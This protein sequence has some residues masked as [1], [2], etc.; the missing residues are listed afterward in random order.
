MSPT[1]TTPAMTQAGMI[2][3]TAAYM[4]PEQARGK[5]VDKRAD[6][7][8]FGVVLFEMLTG[9]RAFPG[10]D[11]TDTLAAVVQH[12]AG[13]GHAACRSAF[14]ALRRSASSGACRKTPSSGFRTSPRCACALDGAFET[15]APSRP[16][17]ATTAS[18]GRLPWV[19]ALAVAVAGIARDWRCPPC[20][21]FAR[22]LPHLRLRCASRSRRP[23]Q[24]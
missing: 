11:L 23:H 20:G 5:A 18:R 4:A 14:R 1:I 9:Q 7:W 12:R 6:I 22:R 21:I 15:A 3:G 16:R 24:R 8:A 10:E 13:A 19:A 17:R 2:L